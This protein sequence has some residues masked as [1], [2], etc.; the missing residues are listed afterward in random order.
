[1]HVVFWHD[2]MKPSQLSR[3]L[4]SKHPEHEDKPPHFF[5]SVFPLENFS[6]LNK[7]LEDSLELSYWIVKDEKP[8]I[9]GETLVLPDTGKMAEIIEKTIWQ[10]NEIHSFASKYCWKVHRK[11]CWRSKELE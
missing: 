11:H 3:Q 7:S 1:M 8:H 2:S 9:I 4:K 6:K 10:Q 5:F